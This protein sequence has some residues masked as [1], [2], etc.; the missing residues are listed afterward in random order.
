MPIPPW[1]KYGECL[2][3]D[4][5]IFFDQDW[6][7]F[8]VGVCTTCPVKDVCLTWALTHPKMT[9]FGV[10]GGLTEGQRRKTG[11]KRQRVKCP[12]CG[13]E[14]VEQLRNRHEGCLACGLSWPI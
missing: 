12:G 10:W 8:A 14:D 9:Q 6:E 4:P 5:D 3:H 13:S 7:A 2:H 1:H 11:T